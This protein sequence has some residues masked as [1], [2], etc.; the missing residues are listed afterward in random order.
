MSGVVCEAMVFIVV[1]G[2]NW[3]VWGFV[4]FY[5]FSR[6]GGMVMVLVLVLVLE[7]V[8]CDCDYYCY[9]MLCSMIGVD[10]MIWMIWM[11]LWCCSI[12]I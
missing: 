4:C 3:M 10:W 6:A 7:W 12:I 8:D 11:R 2:M 1:M 5:Y 9:I